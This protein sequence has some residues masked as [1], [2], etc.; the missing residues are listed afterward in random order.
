MGLKARKPSGRSNLGIN[1]TNS[2]LVLK[3]IKVKG[4]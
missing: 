2:L 3:F 4:L 1:S